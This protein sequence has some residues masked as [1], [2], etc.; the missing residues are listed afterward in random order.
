[1]RAAVDPL[2]AY[3]QLLF[4]ILADV[5]DRAGL[6]RRGQADQGAG[7]LSPEYSRMKRAM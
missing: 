4:E 1:M 5:L 6:G 2:Q 3:S 7:S